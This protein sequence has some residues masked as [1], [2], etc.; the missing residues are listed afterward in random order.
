MDI[1]DLDRF[2]EDERRIMKSKVREV[3]TPHKPITTERFFRGRMEELKQLLSTLNTPGEHALL[4]GD[5]G[6]GKSSLA[7]ITA[8]HLVNLTNRKLIKKRC[9]SSDTFFSIIEIVLEEAGYSSRTIS[10]TKQQGFTLS[11]FNGSISSGNSSLVDG[12]KS[13]AISPSWVAQIIGD[14]NVLLLI[15][16]FDAIK[17]VD[18][19]Y[20]IAELIKQLSDS[21]SKLKILIVGIAESSSELTEG[22]PSVQRCLKEVKL[23][24][25]SY[26]DLRQ[27][28]KY[29]ADALGLNFNREVVMRI[30]RLSSGYAYFTHLL[31][32]KAAENAIIDERDN[33][34]FDNLNFAIKEAINDCES[35]LQKLYELSIKNSVDRYQK[36]LYAIALCNEEFIR[37]KDVVTK[38]RLK[39][40][41]EISMSALNSCFSRIAS[42]DNSRILKRIYKG[43]YRFSDPR[44]SSYIRIV[45]SYMYTPDEYNSDQ[46]ID[47]SV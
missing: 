31:A 36:V 11:A 30:I 45:Q 25:M 17:S 2:A 33:I 22:H 6:V 12:V 35:S 28:I 4:Y 8:K 15:D 34:A 10:V 9:D 37:K 14:L 23:N 26:E 41:E 27:I 47:A 46:N 32:L 39:F 13:Q 20:K 16:E 29:G 44:M 19:K 40:N 42:E 43:I 21:D 38:Y 7:N 1:L 5:R 3:F 18:D 24:R